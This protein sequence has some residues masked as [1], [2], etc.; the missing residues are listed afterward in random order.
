MPNNNVLTAGERNAIERAISEVELCC[1]FSLA[2]E[3]RALLAAHPGQPNCWCETCRPITLTDM[4]MVLCPTCGNKRCPHATNHRNACTGSNEPGQPGSSWEH[5]KPRRQ[6]E[7]RDAIA[8]SKRILGLVDAYHENPTS[9]TRTALRVALMDEF[10]PEPASCGVIAAALTVIEAD[11][12]QTLTNE[13]VDALDIAIKIQRGELTLPDPRAE[14]TDELA[15]LRNALTSINGIRN[16]II[17]LHTLN[18]SEHVYPLVAALDAAGFEGMEYPEARAFYGTMLDRCNAT[19]QDA[20]R[21]RCLRR[22]QH[23]SVVNGIGDVLRADELDAAMD[24]AR[25]GEKQ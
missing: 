24:A 12:S 15:K 1:Q 22:G 25:E 2:N 8:R 7:P 11:R 20:D 6:P 21:Y 19:E 16:S 18:W 3:L 5:V 9:D 23:W 14:V 4:R 17:G 13:H 10:Q